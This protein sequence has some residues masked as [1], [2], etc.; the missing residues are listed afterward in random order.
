MLLITSWD[1]LRSLREVETVSAGETR[2]G[3]MCNMTESDKAFHEREMK[4]CIP[5]R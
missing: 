1:S 3:G 2:G 5:P 4:I